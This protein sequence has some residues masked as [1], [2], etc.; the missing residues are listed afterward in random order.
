MIHALVCFFKETKFTYIAMYVKNIPH[1]GW[2]QIYKLYMHVY[3]NYYPL[4]SLNFKPALTQHPDFP[5]KGAY[6]P[7]NQ[8]KI[9]FPRVIAVKHRHPCLIPDIGLK[10]G[11]K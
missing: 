3:G 1:S 2:F 6:F 10:I 5:W 8:K 4:L 11:P 7:P 9:L